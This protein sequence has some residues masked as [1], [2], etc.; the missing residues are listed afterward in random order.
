MRRRAQRG[1]TLVE[2]LVVV[3]IMA[4]LAGTVVLGFVGADR[5]K[6]LRTEAERL[7]AVIELARVESL[8]RNEEWGLVV[9]RDGYEFKVYVPEKSAWRTVEDRPFQ[10]RKLEAATLVAKVEAI[11]LKD[12]RAR[13]GVPAI[14]IL[15]SGEQT[16][17]EIQLVPLWQS[18]PWIVE[19]D[20]LSRTE[21]R[22][23]A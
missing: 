7:R 14:V 16:P 4:V 6:K 2:T 23:A 9:A 20:G 8:Q 1:F 18:E 5:E 22:R 10:A 19:S 3:V 12:E 17:F 15:S 13:K 11:E 21:V